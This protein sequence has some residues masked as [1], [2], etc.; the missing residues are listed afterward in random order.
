[1]SDQI[2]SVLEVAKDLRCSKAHVYKAITG[3]VPGVSA[4]P[5]I[6]MGRRRLVRRSSL[7]QWKQ[8]NERAAQNATIDA[9]LKNHSVDA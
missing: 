9:S 1:M 3:T 2:L 6:L 8:A 5:A 4:L 7:E